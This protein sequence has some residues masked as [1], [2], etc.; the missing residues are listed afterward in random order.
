M[1]SLLRTFAVPLALLAAALVLG[2]VAF[3]DHW[4]K[5]Q[6]IDRAEVAD[7]YCRHRG[8]DCGATS[9]RT[10]EA[11][12]QDR[13]VGYE[14]AVCLLGLAA[15]GTAARPARRLLVAQGL[16]GRTAF[17]RLFRR[18]GGRE[19][20]RPPKRAG[21]ALLPPRPEGSPY[22]HLQLAGIERDP[23]LSR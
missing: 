17:R 10:L 1:R 19:R 12:W 4:W 15:V 14:I 21:S 22:P 9:W 3:A 20:L 16:Q 23:D 6:R 18:T 8:V 11:H 5:Q 2:G 13:Q 7:W